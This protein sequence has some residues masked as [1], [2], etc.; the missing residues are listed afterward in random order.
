MDSYFMQGPYKAENKFYPKHLFT[1]PADT[2]N[3]TS[4]QACGST[5]LQPQ[6]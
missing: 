3:W 2:G 4:N 6:K 1:P 5:M